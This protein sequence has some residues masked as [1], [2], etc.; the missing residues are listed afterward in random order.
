MILFTLAKRSVGQHAGH[1]I[2]AL[3]PGGEDDGAQ[4][5]GYHG[6]QCPSAPLVPVVGTELE[7][8]LG[9][10][11][12]AGAGGGEDDEP[13]CPDRQLA[14]AVVAGGGGRARLQGPGLLVEFTPPRDEGAQA[15]VT[16]GKGEA[17]A[18]AD[19]DQNDR[20]VTEPLVPGFPRLVEPQ[21]GD[22]GGRHTPV[23]E[24]DQVIPAKGFSL[25]AWHRCDTPSSGH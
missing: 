7:A 18:E 16:P 22:A 11:E 2:A 25:S 5:Q 17:P 6:L 13:E 15:G 12:P 8:H 9:I 23:G 4:V 14:A 20:Q 24:A 19:A 10:L 1:Q 21:V 3:A